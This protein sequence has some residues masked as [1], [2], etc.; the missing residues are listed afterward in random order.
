MNYTVEVAEFIFGKFVY[1]AITLEGVRNQI[2]VGTHG[3]FNYSNMPS[4]RKFTLKNLTP[5]ERPL[6]CRFHT[7]NT[8]TVKL[9]VNV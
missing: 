7:S 8:D 6:L 9:D 4:S 3:R 5:T 1:T 2:V